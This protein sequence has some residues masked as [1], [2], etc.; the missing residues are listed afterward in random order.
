MPKDAPSKPSDK[1]KA[2]AD[3]FSRRERQ[4]MDALYAL[5][6]ASAAQVLEAMPDP[7]G[8]TSVRTFLTIL[9]KKGHVRHEDDGVRYVYA[10]VAPREDAGKDAIQTLKKTFFR[11]SAELLIAALLEEEDIPVEELD[12]LAQLID[13]AR[14]EGR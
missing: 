14:K 3:G 11:D 1:G 9:E 10:P 12:R 5:G 2:G 7:P 6:R 8:Y 4:I 13:K